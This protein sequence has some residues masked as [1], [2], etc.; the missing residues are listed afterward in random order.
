MS[1]AHNLYIYTPCFHSRGRV[2]DSGAPKF[3]S[4]K[5]MPI[6]TTYERQHILTAQNATV[7]Q[8]I[9][10]I[11]DFNF[12]KMMTTHNMLEMLT[13]GTFAPAQKSSACAFHSLVKLLYLLLINALQSITKQ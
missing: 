13:R 4:G 8:T 6:K 1:H 9:V 2:V 11:Y 12:M 5:T 10:G 3:D 7:N